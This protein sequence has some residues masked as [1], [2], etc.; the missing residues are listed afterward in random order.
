M[1]HVYALVDLILER[2]A[3][4]RVEDESKEFCADTTEPIYMHYVWE[5]ESWSVSQILKSCS[6]L[7]HNIHITAK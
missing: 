2:I 6:Q 4:E 3:G 7:D 1:S 5:P